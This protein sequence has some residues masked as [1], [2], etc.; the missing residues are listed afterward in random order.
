MM[1]VVFKEIAHETDTVGQYCF[2]KDKSQWDR[3]G[4]RE[5]GIPQEVIYI[6]KKTG[7]AITKK[8]HFW[9]CHKILSGTENVQD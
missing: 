9:F 7:N 4:G 2:S 6:W 3:E 1:K 8:H 5:G